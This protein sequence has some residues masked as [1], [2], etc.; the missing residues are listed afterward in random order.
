MLSLSCLVA[1]AYDWS[2][3]RASHEAGRSGAHP[4][5]VALL[6]KVRHPF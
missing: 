5:Q 3:L 4:R 1:G 2:L 6:R